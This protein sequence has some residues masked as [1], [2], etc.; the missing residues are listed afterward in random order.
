MTDL[1]P[2][3]RTLQE[4]LLR[5]YLDS[6]PDKR[7][8]LAEA[9]QAVLSEGSGTES[10]TRLRRLTHRLAGS[11]GSYGLN[12]VGLAALA[13]EQAIQQAGAKP[14]GL[15]GIR[16]RVEELLGILEDAQKIT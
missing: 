4:K 1:S 10:L 7:A 12:E 6:L 16:Y 9:W 5:R 3:G 2:E 11:A 13:L 8:D 14:P 15:D